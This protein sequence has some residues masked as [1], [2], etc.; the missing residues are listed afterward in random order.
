[1]SKPEQ[2]PHSKSAI[3]GRGWVNAPSTL[4][5]GHEF[6]GRRV[7]VGQRDRLV[8]L[9]TGLETVEVWFLSGER[10]SARVP[11]IFVGWG[12]PDTAKP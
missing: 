4:Q 6:N 10:E 8:D 12:W 1:M 5:A 3:F 2:T 9:Q 11:L 7:L